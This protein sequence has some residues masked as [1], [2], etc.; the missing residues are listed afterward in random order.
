M[1]EIDLDQPAV[2]VSLRLEA[3]GS[4]QAFEVLFTDLSEPCEAFPLQCWVLSPCFWL[5][6]LADV[7]KGTERPCLQVLQ[8]AFPGE[9]HHC[10]AP[11]AFF[12]PL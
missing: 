12:L 8:L 6:F 9:L 3:C 10:P 7:L 5:P 2:H 4:C 11:W 1:K